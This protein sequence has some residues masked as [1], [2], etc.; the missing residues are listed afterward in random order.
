[1]VSRSK[2]NAILVPALA[3][4]GATLIEGH[5]RADAA[6]DL[7]RRGDQ[8]YARR[9]S[10]RVTWEAIGFYRQALARQP[11]S[12][13]AHWK[14]ARAFFWL[15]DNT[16]DK[17]RDRTLGGEG[18][19]YAQRAVQLRPAGVEGHFYSAM[20]LGE[21]AKSMSV[22]KA[23][24]SSARSK[25]LGALDAVL[26]IDRRFEGCGADR[27][28]GMYYHRLPWPLRDVKKALEH[29]GRA[30]ACD[31]G[32]ARTRFYLAQVLLAEKRRDEARRQI[33]LCLEAAPTS[34]PP[35]LLRY[36]WHC[37]QLQGKL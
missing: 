17:E 28:Y 3:L 11:D 4:L 5:A 20:C 18:Y 15:A 32:R 36:Q 29:L 16:D 1:V 13:E 34:D 12:Y 24:R 8:L 10:E 26:R 22:V 33:Q 35:E 6:A 31:G 23:L 37:R 21:H 25:I 30:V 27:A 2:P 14:L 19:R 9:F 7:V